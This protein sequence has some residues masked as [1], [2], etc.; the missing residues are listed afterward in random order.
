[1]SRNTCNAFLFFNLIRTKKLM[2][3]SRKHMVL[4]KR[5]YDKSGFIRKKGAKIK[6][7]RSMLKKLLSLTLLFIL[8]F[9]VSGCYMGTSAKERE[10]GRKTG[11]KIIEDINDK[12]TNSIVQQF[13]KKV[14]DNF[15]LEKQT[16]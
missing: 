11:L 15:D 7:K 13:S 2:L 3:N 8:I 14:Q 1:M 6:M 16:I 5:W 4:L 12:D 10:Q 9:S